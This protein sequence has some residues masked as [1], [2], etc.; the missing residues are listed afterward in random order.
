MSIIFPPNPKTQ[1]IQSDDARDQINKITKSES[2]YLDSGH[3]EFAQSE[4]AD[5]DSR[6]TKFTVAYEQLWEANSRVRHKVLQPR[7]FH[8]VLCAFD[9]LTLN[10]LTEALR[11]D[12][13]DPES[14]QKDLKP[15][16][17]E[18]LCHNFLVTNSTAGLEWAHQSAKDF[19]THHMMEANTPVFSEASNHIC[20]SKIAL[21]LLSQ[22]DHPAW[23]GLNLPY[24]QESQSSERQAARLELD[25]ERIAKTI[26]EVNEQDRAECD[27]DETKDIQFDSETFVSREQIKILA[28]VF[29]AASFASYVVARFVYHLRFICDTTAS[30]SGLEELLRTVIVS[31]KSALPAVAKLFQTFS[32]LN[33]R[34][35]WKGLKY[36]E[37]REVCWP[38][39]SFTIYSQLVRK[40]PMAREHR[41]PCEI[42]R[43]VCRDHDGEALVAPLQLLTLINTPDKALFQHAVD[44]SKLKLK[45]DDWNNYPA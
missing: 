6:H 29:K 22:I 44:L 43:T 39:E 38:A 14:Y 7:L 4:S 34:L 37:G 9:D 27:P 30:M 8:L 35:K 3:A 19:V 21:Q 16:H 15:E 20:M 42:M 5:L 31:R 28:L 1:I 12:P 13:E 32:S 11:I 17:V 45:T 33:E 2:D 36:N 41:T 10:Q 40:V 23:N 18:W 25:F 26:H 24:W